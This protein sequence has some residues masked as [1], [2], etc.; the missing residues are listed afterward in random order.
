MRI[1]LCSL[2]LSL[3]LS[4]PGVAAPADPLRAQVRA[5]THAPDRQVIA[6]TPAMGLVWLKRGARGHDPA[7]IEGVE[8][9]G[10]V[11]DDALATARGWRSMRLRLDVNCAEGKLVARGFEVFDG[12]DRAGRARDLPAP[13]GWVR[14]AHGAYLEPVVEAACGTQ[15]EV[16]AE[17]PKA[18]ASVQLDSAPPP[19]EAPA[20]APSLGPRIAGLYSAQIKSSPDRSEAQAAVDQWSA[21]GTAMAGLSPRVEPAQVG[22]RSVYRAVVAG[23][24]TRDAADAFC[25]KVRDTG[26]ACFVRRRTAAAVGVAD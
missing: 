7:L 24:Q 2:W 1:T 17:K 26:G 19:A 10:E 5:W 4:A 11:M 14:P 6:V 23:F 8:I 25:G 21:K 12:H 9:Q 3:A 16:S 13:G 15:P 18:A 22:G 20:P